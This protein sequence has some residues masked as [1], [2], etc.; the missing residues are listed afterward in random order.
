MNRAPAPVM[1]HGPGLPTSL[2]VHVP[3]CERKC[4]YC[5]FNSHAS[6]TVPDYAAYVDA[7]LADLDHECRSGPAPVIDSV[8]VGGGTPSLMP[9]RELGRLLDG[10][11]A[12]TTLSAGA[13]ITVEANPGSAEAA[14]FADYRAAGVNRL[15]LGIQSLDDA[16]L[17]SLG[18]IHDA[19]AARAAFAKASAAGFDNINLDIMYG[20][21]GQAAAAAMSD[22]R[23]AIAL[24]P[25]HLSWYELT[26]EPNTLFHHRPPALPDDDT[27][28]DIGDAGVALLADAGYARYEI[29]AFARPGA[30]CRHN[31]NYWGFG[32]YVGIGAGAHGKRTVAGSGVIR[33]AKQRR[34]ERYLATAANGAV[35][36]TRRVDRS[37]LPLEFML[38]AMRLVDGVPVGWL[39]ARAGVSVA[40]VRAPLE[41][42]AA[43]G[44]ALH[45][46][47]RIRPTPLG[48]RF[49]N[50]LLALFEP[51]AEVGA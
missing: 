50:E 23:D 8:F 5:D 49:L 42:A 25:A 40:A 29:S 32:D 22:L 31:L 37:E 33:T 44:L 14:R 36:S 3:W 10:I 15:S 18:R 30:R 11:A 26:I 46:G 20:L 38:N 19:G 16:S 6:P 34:P 47:G 1:E 45:A 21:P 9:G 27:V 24:G 28:A 41:R 7:L 17:A 51:D 39:E 12:R 13:E 35:S 4:P 2:Y 48:L 43:L